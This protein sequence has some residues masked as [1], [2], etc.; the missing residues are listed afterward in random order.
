MR[1]AWPAANQ[2]KVRGI[3]LFLP[4]LIRTEPA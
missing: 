1:S 3:A 2:R 4:L